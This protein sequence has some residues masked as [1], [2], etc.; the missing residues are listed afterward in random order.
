MVIGFYWCSDFFLSSCGGGA[1]G[2]D[3]SMDTGSMHLQLR[4]ESASPA[5]LHADRSAIGIVCVDF[6]IE[7][8][9]AKVYDSSNSE[10]VAAS[11]SCSDFHGT[12]SRVPAG[13]GLR[14]VVAGIVSD[15]IH[16]QGEAGDIT[17]SAEENKQVDIAMS[18][19]GE[20][21][22]SPGISSTNLSESAVDVAIDSVITATFTERIVAASVN[23]STFTLATCGTIIKGTTPTSPLVSVTFQRIRNSKIR[24][25]VFTASIRDQPPSTAV[26][27]TFTIRIAPAATEV[28]MAGLMEI[29]RKSVVSLL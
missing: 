8:I 28:P 11:W 6:E 25:A 29:G 15:A 20:D 1:G 18:Y 2:S 16:W 13:T 7:T 22:T 14:V 21:E 3:T 4:W 24:Q 9:D 17:L 27:Q 26:I 5:L 12:L 10:L 19:I 23:T